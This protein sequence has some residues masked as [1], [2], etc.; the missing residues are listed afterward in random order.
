MGILGNLL[1]TGN[2]FGFN[3]DSK[4]GA[5]LPRSFSA[6]TFTSAPQSNDPRQAAAHFLLSQS[7]ILPQIMGGAMMQ[8]S[9]QQQPSQAN[10]M[11]PNGDSAFSNMMRNTANR[12]GLGEIDPAYLRYQPRGGLYAT[13]WNSG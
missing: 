2:P 11:L 3:S 6:N 9:G 7:G 8:G 12:S 10:G 13:N 1:R 4:M 5:E